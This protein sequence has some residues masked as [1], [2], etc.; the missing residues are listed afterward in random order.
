MSPLGSVSGRGSPP[1]SPDGAPRETPPAAVPGGRSWPPLCLPRFWVGR[2]PCDPR[3]QVIIDFS[4]WPLSVC[5][6]LARHAGTDENPLPGFLS[7]PP[8]PGPPGPQLPPHRA[9]AAEATD[10]TLL[11]RGPGPGARLDLR[12][13]L[14]DRPSSCSQAPR[15]CSRRLLAQSP[16]R[17]FRVFVTS[18]GWPSST[19]Q[20]PRSAA[21]PRR[22]GPSTTRT[23]CAALGSGLGLSVPQSPH[24]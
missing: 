10:P 16:P 11:N 13:P 1:P 8:R 17:W 15:F 24:L 3:W 21:S 20:C 14:P 4:S 12:A 22:A 2:Y 7:P 6:Y 9:A 18:G 5:L 19:L 23:S